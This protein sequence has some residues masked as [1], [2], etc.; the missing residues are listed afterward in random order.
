MS[1]EFE[2]RILAS[3]ENMSLKAPAGD[4]F[5]GAGVALA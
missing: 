2:I 4:M 3:N 5:S 1:S